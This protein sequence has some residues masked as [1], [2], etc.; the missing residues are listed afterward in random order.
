MWGILALLASPFPLIA[1]FILDAF[2]G[3]T[4]PNQRKENVNGQEDEANIVL[5]MKKHPGDLSIAIG[6]NERFSIIEEGY[7]VEGI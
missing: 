4:N 7:H 6:K 3:D 1:P 2:A 5:L